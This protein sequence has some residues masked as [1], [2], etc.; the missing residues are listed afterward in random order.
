MFKY[1]SVLPFLAVATACTTMAPDYERPDVDDIVAETYA[2]IAATTPDETAVTRLGWSE[3]FAD[4]RL[5]ALI[6]SGL[7][8]NRDLRVAIL[9]V[10]QIRA[11]Y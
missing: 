6:K 1:L 8:K 10:E 4:E 9:T 7:E 11:R 3:F 2:G 5:K